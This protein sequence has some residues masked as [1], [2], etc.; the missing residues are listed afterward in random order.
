MLFV[1]NLPTETQTDERRVICYLISYNIIS[2]VDKCKKQQSTAL[3]EK[4]T[5]AQLL[6][7]LAAFSGTQI[8]ITVL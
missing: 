4:L 2:H 1:L 8:F 5:V 7:K 3:V 6:K